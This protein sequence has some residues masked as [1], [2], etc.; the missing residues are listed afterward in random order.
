MLF[1]RGGEEHACTW[2]EGDA[3]EGWDITVND[4]GPGLG[5]SLV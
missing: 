5:C 2:S 4:L 1:A 3:L